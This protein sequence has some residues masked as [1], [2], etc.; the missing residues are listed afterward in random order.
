MAADRS[1][2]DLTAAELPGSV[3]GIIAA[4]LDGLDPQDKS[5]LQDAAV[6]GKTFWVGAIAAI[7]ARGRRA[8][9]R[10][11]GGGGSRSRAPAPGAGTGEVRPPV[12]PLLGRRRDR[13]RVP[14]S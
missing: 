7:G 8:A 14:P 12:A 11:R 1:F 6:V 3:Q 10:G 4:R 13:I 2:T 9:R 5:L